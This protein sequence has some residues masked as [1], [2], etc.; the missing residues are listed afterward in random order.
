MKSSV[1]TGTVNLLLKVSPILLSSCK[2]MAEGEF[3]IHVGGVGRLPQF[4][5]D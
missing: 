3:Y 2:T 5:S 4:A 1:I